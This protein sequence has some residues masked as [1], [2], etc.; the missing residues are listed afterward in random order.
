[1]Q[2]N[3]VIREGLVDGVCGFRVIAFIKGRSHT[4]A[5]FSSLQQKR[6]QGSWRTKQAQREQ[7]AEKMCG[8]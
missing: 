7:N 8:N 2:G 1:V 3:E 6:K 5:V 4:A